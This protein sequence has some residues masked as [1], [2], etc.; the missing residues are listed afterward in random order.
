MYYIFMNIQA[1]QCNSAHWTEVG[2]TKVSDIFQGFN[3]LFT[4]ITVTGNSLLSI[5][6]RRKLFD[7]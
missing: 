3:L 1:K 4:A 6:L 2:V 7:F 5:Y